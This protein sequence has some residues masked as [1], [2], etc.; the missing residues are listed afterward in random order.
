MG[1]S[2]AYGGSAGFGP[3]RDPIAEWV[4]G[5]DLPSP[6]DRPPEAKDGDTAPGSPPA[7]SPPIPPQVLKSLESLGRSLSSGI[8][9][10]TGAPARPRVHGA[11]SGGGGGGAMRATGGRSR[12]RASASGGAA[13]AAGYAAGAGGGV[14]EPGVNLTAED[15]AGLSTMQKAAK[16]VAVAAPGP[17]EEGESAFHDD[18]IRRAN[19]DFAHWVVMQDG[20]VSAEDLVRAWVGCYVWVIWQREVGHVLRQMDDPQEMENREKEMR[21]ALDARM[22]GLNVKTTGVTAEDFQQVI[23]ACI[24]SLD[25]VFGTDSP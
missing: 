8:A 18:E 3:V 2:G 7:A 12:T 10:P 13:A 14:A 22:G 21:A 24:E 19:G 25:R 15:F 16:I 20:P 1:T 9:S 11:R 6:G 17:R 23:A 4:G 5:G